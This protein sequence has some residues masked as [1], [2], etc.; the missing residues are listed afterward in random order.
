MD[1]RHF[2]QLSSALAISAG[3]MGLPAFAKAAPK[4]SL[5]LLIE[6]KGGNDGLNTLVPYKDPLYFSARPTISLS[7]DTLLPVS[8]SL[9]LH[10][11]LSALLPQWDTKQ[12]AL[13][14]GVGYPAPNFSHFRSID[15]WDTASNSNQYLQEGWLSRFVQTN[16]KQFN[17]IADGLIF[18]TDTLG[19]FAGKSNALV[20]SKNLK[21]ETL[22]EQPT[23][24][25]PASSSKNDALAH[26]NA[27][28]AEL[29]QAKYGLRKQDVATN[30]PNSTFGNDLKLLASY[31]AGGSEINIARVSLSG[32]DTHTN[33]LSRQKRLLQEF[34]EGITAFSEEMKQQNRWDDTLILT[35]A[36]FGR[37]VK[38]NQSGGTDHGTANVHFALGGRV[39]GGFYGNTPSLAQLDNGNLVANID[40]RQ[41]YATVLS[42]WWQTSPT[43]VLG[44]PFEN[45][46]FI[47]S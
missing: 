12:L 19:P 13:L 5:F 43:K 4:K 42:Q 41:I 45:I 17:Q 18:G 31:L 14:Q 35:Y 32:F 34:A 7:A 15:I 46:P 39:K 30:F 11:S 9:A 16:G 37:R 20:I 23:M 10:H 3:S 21:L 1:R 40:F 38:E 29:N 33:Q 2:L 26:L 25:Q 27:V 24:I 22:D 36:E 8:D 28:S 44:K 6:L 47:L